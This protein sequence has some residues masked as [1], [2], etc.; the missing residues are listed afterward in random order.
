MASIFSA[1]LSPLKLPHTRAHIV[2]PHR[3]LG[4]PDFPIYIPPYPFYW[5]GSSFAPDLSEDAL[6]FLVSV[7]FPLAASI[8]CGS[9]LRPQDSRVPLGYPVFLVG[10]SL[11]Y[12]V[13]FLSRTAI[14]PVS[15]L[16]LWT[17]AN[18]LPPPC[19]LSSIRPVPNLYRGPLFPSSRLFSLSA[20]SANVLCVT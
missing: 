11:L 13:F 14:I 19:L 17:P 8:S 12:P 5:W 3:S 1:R 18:A 6:I 20:R 16:Y 2:Y 4:P 9:I 10:L 7:F 15:S